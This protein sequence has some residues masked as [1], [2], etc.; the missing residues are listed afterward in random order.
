MVF[1]MAI[2]SCAALANP[3]ITINAPTNYTTVYPEP[4]GSFN[5]TITSNESHNVTCKLQYNLN[6]TMIA[7]S[8]TSA[9]NTSWKY[10]FIVPVTARNGN[11][12]NISFSCGNTSALTTWTNSTPL[13]FRLKD[14][15]YSI[16]DRAITNSTML[17]S[18]ASL[19]ITIVSDNA[20]NCTYNLNNAGKALMSQSP[21]RGFWTNASAVA[22][23][24]TAFGAWNNI[25]YNCSDS[26]GNFSSITTYFKL[27]LTDP[28][29]PATPAFTLGNKS[30][31]GN[32]LNI[33]AN[34]SDKNP[35]GCMASIYWDNGAI[36]NSTGEVS[37]ST[38]VENGVCMVNVTSSDI[39]HDGY[40]EIMIAS[41]DQA[42]HYAKETNQSYIIRRLK[43]G[44]NLATG[45]E[46]KTLAQIA[47]EVPNVTY[48]SV[49]D[50]EQ[51]V[52]WTHIV[53]GSV[54][55]T[56]GSNLSTNMSSGAAYIYVTQDV[57][58]IRRY[59]AVPSAWANTSIMHNMTAGKQPINLIGVTKAITD[60]NATMMKNVCYNSTGGISFANCANITW[61]T[62]YSELDGKY[63]AYYRN[64]LSV[65]CSLTSDK[66]NLTIGDSLW[67]S[68]QNGANFTLGRSGW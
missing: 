55:A 63:C 50:N 10:D 5:V 54:N 48:V 3:S 51:K 15:D 13:L 6:G 66:Y 27:D 56:L 62:W 44:W 19:N 42:G 59:Y 30:T 65:G 38:A 60:L 11:W 64:R 39:A 67:I 58:L 36:F 23:P 24:E 53:G 8:N 26:S 22:N 12:Q 41:K 35:G 32:Y 1:A 18:N 14:A 4:T 40:A 47:A 16:L 7:M 2:F 20:T 33:T 46:N 68:T 45:F 49:W 17:S 37:Y 25:T 61:V 52:Y 34:V 29:F 43:A 9:A 21:N 57:T 31:G 28:S